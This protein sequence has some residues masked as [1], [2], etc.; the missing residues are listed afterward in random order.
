[1]DRVDWYFRQLVTEAELD[2]AFDKVETADQ[3]QNKDSGAVG[4]MSGLTV[5]ES[6]VP[7]LNVIVAVGTAYGKQGRRVRVAAQQTLDVSQD[8]NSVTTTVATPGNAKWIS[9]FLK[10]DRTL[11]DPRVDGNSATVYFQ[12]AET[13]GFKVVQSAEAPVPTKPALEAD[14]ILLVDIIRLE[15]QTTI[16]NAYLSASRREE[17]YVVTGTPHALQDGTT[18]EAFT[19]LLGWLNDH[20]NDPAAH[21]AA[22]VDYDGGNA[23]ADGTANPATTVEAQLDKIVADLTNAGAGTSGVQKIGVEDITQGGFTIS[24]GTLWSAL[25]T[26]VDWIN[27]LDTQAVKITGNQTIAGIKTF[28]T[29]IISQAQILLNTTPDTTAMVDGN[30]TPTSYKLIFQF[31]LDANTKFR[32]YVVNTGGANTGAILVSL[33]A[34]WVSGTTWNRDSVGTSRKVMLAVLTQDGIVLRRYNGAA[35]VAFDDSTDEEGRFVVAV[36][37]S[38]VPG[39]PDAV[40]IDDAGYLIAPGEVVVKFHARVVAANAG[41][42]YAAMAYF[43]KQFDS[44]PSSIAF[45]GATTNVTSGVPG[46]AGHAYTS[47][48]SVTYEALGAGNATV[49]VDITV[50]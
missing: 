18:K 33:N 27:Q 9:V 39:S 31:R 44:T 43:P 23:W 2:G 25:D 42:D 16:Q 11:S 47:G 22:D 48:V 13:F 10:A 1:M 41:D 5:E 24:A 14:H 4:V 50:S 29:G 3:N 7:D 26:L 20:L 17:Q 32:L 19:A 15:G 45:S 34:R 36:P 35:V 8:F 49:T 37:M 6:A 46:L 21:P 38:G 12:R 28:A 40:N 30:D